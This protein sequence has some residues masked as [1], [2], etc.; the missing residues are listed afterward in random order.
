MSLYRPTESD[1]QT[2]AGMNVAI[3]TPCK[4]YE[5]PVRFCQSVANLVGYS[6]KHGLKVET[7]GVMERMPV[8]WAR[9]ELCRQVKSIQEITHLFWLDDDH[10]FNADMLCYLARHDKDVVSAV[11]YGRVGRHL[12]VVYVKDTTA[13]KYKHF[14]IVELPETLCEVDAI[15]F[16]ACLM[17]R[18]VLDRMPEPWF[19]FAPGGVGEDV[20]F[21]VHAKQA[22]IKIW[23]DGS[24]TVGHIG[25]PQVVDRATHLR[26]M[27]A[28]KD[29]Y[30]DRIRVGLGGQVH[31]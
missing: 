15:G 31:A 29:E 28:N 27:E 19:T 8:H 18:D 13:D 2:Y 26:F 12:P 30:A 21:C 22:G 6:A 20:Y 25:E 24:Y 9:Q 16:G 5:V 23:C 3:L 1:K 7:M 17:R 14:P 4:D 10:I 11:Y